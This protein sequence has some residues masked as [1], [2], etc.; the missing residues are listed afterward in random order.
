MPNITITDVTINNVM[1]VFLAVFIFQFS[2]H[3]RPD[4]KNISRSF[5]ALV[6]GDS[7]ISFPLIYI[8][9]LCHDTRNNKSMK[10]HLSSLRKSDL[11][12][13]SN[14]MNIAEITAV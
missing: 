8:V 3:G 5:N 11:Y 10:S 13:A 1:I 2:S 9:M 14:H 12:C 6:T 4:R 7:M